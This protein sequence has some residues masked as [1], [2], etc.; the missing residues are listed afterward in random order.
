MYACMYVCVCLYVCM[1]ICIGDGSLSK[2]HIFMCIVIS[3]RILYVHKV[4]QGE[5]ECNLWTSIYF[6]SAAI[7]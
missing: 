6:A 5:R 7:A 3:I 1:Y 4:R 2:I